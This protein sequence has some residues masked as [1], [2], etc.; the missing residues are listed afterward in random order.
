MMT[1]GLFAI[2]TRYKRDDR[3]GR[4]TVPTNLLLMNHNASQADKPPPTLN[5]VVKSQK[6]EYQSYKIKRNNT[7][8]KLR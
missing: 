5:Q 8:F 3:P 7:D 1:R 6:D 4:A 2:N